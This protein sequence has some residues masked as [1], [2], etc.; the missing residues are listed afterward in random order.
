MMILQEVCTKEQAVAFEVIDQRGRR[1]MPDQIKQRLEA[2]KKSE[3][4]NEQ[5]ISKLQK[6]EE[7]RKE[8]MRR[9]E[10]AE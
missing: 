4:S 3:I 8:L 5:L 2:A 6:A 1:A 10:T 7:K 9:E